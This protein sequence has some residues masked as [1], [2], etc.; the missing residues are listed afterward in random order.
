MLVF[1]QT[2]EKSTGTYT[3]KGE[4]SLTTVTVAFELLN[5]GEIEMSYTYLL[6]N[7]KRTAGGVHHLADDL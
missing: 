1:R 7:V 2:N 5:N 3:L 4:I 6:L